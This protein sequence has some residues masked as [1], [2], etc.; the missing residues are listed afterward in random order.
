M[1]C[2]DRDFRDAI[3]KT[4]KSVQATFYRVDRWGQGLAACLGM[5]YDQSKRRIS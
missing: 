4:T 5:T 2:L 1:M 3:E